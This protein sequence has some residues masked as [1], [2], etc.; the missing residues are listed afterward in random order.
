MH[1]P[2]WAISIACADGWPSFH[3]YTITVEHAG[4]LCL[5][6]GPPAW[7]E[8]YRAK[9]TELWCKTFHSSDHNS[10]LC[11]LEPPPEKH[12]RPATYPST[13]Q[14]TCKQYNRL[15][16]NCNFS[17]RCRYAHKC[18]K[19]DGKPTVSACSRRTVP[20]KHKALRPISRTATWVHCS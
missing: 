8:L 16:S 15:N 3:T 19:C 12:P 5:N 10:D 6:Q 14:E 11:P 1:L 17:T 7:T 2:S 13:A 20:S 18:L 4:I 9:S